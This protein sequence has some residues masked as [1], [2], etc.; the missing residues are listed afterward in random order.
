MDM[1]FP[2][3]LVTIESLL[4][5]GKRAEAGK[6]HSQ[7]TRRETIVDEAGITEKAIR[8]EQGSIFRMWPFKH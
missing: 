8:T 2:I 5:T 4:E 7:Y 3:S 6:P 1:Y